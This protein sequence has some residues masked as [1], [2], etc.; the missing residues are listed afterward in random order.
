MQ[1]QICQICESKRSSCPWDG[2]WRVA[3]A[4]TDVGSLERDSLDAVRRSGGSV[5]S[6]TRAPP[7]G[8]SPPFGNNGRAAR[9]YESAAGPLDDDSDDFGD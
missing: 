3:K 2:F 1:I 7:P 8:L 5:A 6:A 9:A 4:V